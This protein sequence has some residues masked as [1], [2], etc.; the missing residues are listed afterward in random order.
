MPSGNPFEGLPMLGDLA[1]MI[2]GQG[3]LNWDAARQLAVSVTAEGQPVA[4]VDPVVRIDFEQ[5]TTIAE[6]YVAQQT[7][8][9]ST[10]RSIVPVT[11]PM[12]AV[13]SLDAYRPLFERL[14]TALAQA[15]T[16]D[17][18]PNTADPSLAM[19]AG[20]Q[21]LM[22][23]TNLGVAAGSMIG[24]LALKVFGDHDLPIPRPSSGE[25]AV[26]PERIDE[27]ADDWS[28]AR[29]DLRMWVCVH[30]LTS[31]AVMSVPHIRAELGARLDAYAAAFRP[32]PE[33]LARL[34]DDM[35]G[36]D[37][38]D[39]QGALASV[40]SKP[41]A[42]LGTTVSP[43]QAALA[44]ALNDMVALV[45]AV[46]DYHV[47][48]VAARLVGANTPLS[49]AVRRRRL[50]TSGSDQSLQGLFGLRLDRNRLDRGSSFVSGVI[51]R[52]GETGLARLFQSQQM[53]PTA[54]EFEAPGL[55]LARTDLDAEN[56]QGG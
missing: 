52:A 40:L 39:M 2:A 5:L 28:L 27:F 49:E 29:N 13:R 18:S 53:L 47:D 37:P 6:R 17:D 4:N 8:L 14:A 26:I 48:Q 1:K 10:R 38:T 32:D 44:P 36:T 23:P 11:A 22:L 24:H 42:L 12:W 46:T 56:E 25:C 54:S 30:E 9:E 55:W 7:G 34:F 41:E 51:E 21:R 45:L 43:R 35:P 31:A 16:D 50:D 15:P 3:P 20:L 33:G 19:L